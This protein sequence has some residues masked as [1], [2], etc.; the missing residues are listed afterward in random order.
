[1]VILFLPVLFALISCVQSNL[2]LYSD[3][4]VTMQCQ[5]FNNWYY[6]IVH[7]Q[8]QNGGH[9]K[10]LT[11]QSKVKSRWVSGD[12]CKTQGGNSVI[13][14]CAMWRESDPNLFRETPFR[15][16]DST[17]AIVAYLNTSFVPMYELYHCYKDHKLRV[18]KVE[19]RL[20][21]SIVLSL[22]TH[23]Y[24]EQYFLYKKTVTRD[25]NNNNNNNTKPVDITVRRCESGCKIFI[26]DLTMCK[27]H[28]ICVLLY[29]EDEV[30]RE[31]KTVKTIC[32]LENECE[33]MK[34]ITYALIVI[35]G[36]LAIIMLTLFRYCRAQVKK[37]KRSRDDRQPF[38]PVPKGYIFPSP[39]A[40]PEGSTHIVEPYY[41]KVGEIGITN[42]AA[43]TAT[44]ITTEQIA[45]SF[46][47]DTE[48][49]STQSDSSRHEVSAELR[50]EANNHGERPGDCDVAEDDGVVHLPALFRKENV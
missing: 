15:V 10:K 42:F 9:H 8:H 47:S 21:K 25:G 1:M 14:T 16:I 33:Q 41:A 32:P 37:K 11:I 23:K 50:K 49:S 36:I 44:Y 29:Y 45:L 17:N 48:Q 13:V 18:F 40:V 6:Y 46:T 43:D 28:N 5:I 26:S 3:G 4:N 31:C 34:K 22:G 19:K 24:D 38:I 27:K 12:R 35:G 39:P 7:I 30:V 2:P 20:E